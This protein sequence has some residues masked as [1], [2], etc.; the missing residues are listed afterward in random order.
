MTEI[1]F[2]ILNVKTGKAV[3]NWSFADKK[4]IIYSNSP[5]WAMKFDT[6]EDAQKRVKYLEDN[7][8]SGLWSNIKSKSLKK[9]LHTDYRGGIIPFESPL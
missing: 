8:C 7:F 4:H 1:K 3:T 9:C 2:I 6:I 5:D